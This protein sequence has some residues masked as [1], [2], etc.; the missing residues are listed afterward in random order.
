MR[1]TD[2]KPLTFLLPKIVTIGFLMFLSVTYQL[3]LIS[4]VGVRVLSFRVGVLS[5]RGRG[6]ELRGRD[7]W[8]WG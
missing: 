7:S 2:D 4:A 5:C 6:P 8:L 1:D 3:D